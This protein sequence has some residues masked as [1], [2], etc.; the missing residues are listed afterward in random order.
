MN[1][2]SILLTDDLRENFHPSVWGEDT[3]NFIHTVALTYPPN[4]TP[5]IKE[6]YKQFFE[7]L[8][9][10]LPC[11]SCSIHYAQHLQKSPIEEHLINSD[12]LFTWTVDL[13]NMVKRY[14]LMAGDNVIFYPEADIKRE[15]YGPRCQL[16]L[17][18]VYLIMGILSIILL[19]L[20]PK[21]RASSYGKPES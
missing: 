18:K 9:K 8:G 13:R 11:D 10:V 20:M 19:L 1:V 12:T 17:Q 16:K 14:Q 5:A 15:Y 6:Q 2:F 21:Y 4:P 7:S 3:W